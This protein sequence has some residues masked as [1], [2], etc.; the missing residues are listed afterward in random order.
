M[1]ACL[2][3]TVYLTNMTVEKYARSAKYCENR[4]D[5]ES[6][7]EQSVLCEYVSFINNISIFFK[8]EP[9]Q[10][11]EEELLPETGK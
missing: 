3:Y 2:E 11:L 9:L 10:W 1:Q 7:A 4:Q 8:G 6:E 5:C